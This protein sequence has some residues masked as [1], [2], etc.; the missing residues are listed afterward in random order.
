[1]M[2]T[3]FFAKRFA[4]GGGA[5]DADWTW[6]NYTWGLVG[7]FGSG[8]VAEM[9][10]K[11]SGKEFLK[12][13][14]SLLGYKLLVNEL[15]QKSEFV[16]EYFGEEIP[17]EVFMGTDGQYYGAGDT[18][19][20]QDGEVYLMGQDGMWRPTS[21]MGRNPW[22]D[23]YLGPETSLGA[24]LAPP[25]ALGETLAPPGSLGE[26]PYARAFGAANPYQRAFGGN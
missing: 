22:P 8:L 13:G 19:L 26:D 20:G 12:G 21:D 10:R 7:A 4:D 25:G 23:E 11:G 1:M 18:Y 14:L 6:K 3:Q 17:G 24:T 9:I 15:A 2:A 16:Q 5:N